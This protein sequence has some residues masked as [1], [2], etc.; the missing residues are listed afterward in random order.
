[1][2]HTR[3]KQAHPETIPALHRV[4]CTWY[5]EN[6]YLSRALMH[7][8]AAADLDRLGKLVEE[9]AFT[10]LDYQEA[11]TFLSWLNTLPQ[12]V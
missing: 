8:I 6:G 12:P 7:A 2:L 5:A 11:S 4:A 3:L 9:Y 1:M 10:I